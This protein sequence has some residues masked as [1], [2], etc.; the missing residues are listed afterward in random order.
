MDKIEWMTIEIENQIDSIA[1]EDQLQSRIMKL[2]R[3][4]QLLDEVMA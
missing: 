2:I 4:V 1:S 3:L